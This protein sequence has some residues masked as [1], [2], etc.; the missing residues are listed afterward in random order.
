MSPPSQWYTVQK[1]TCASY[2]GYRQGHGKTAGV[3]AGSSVRATLLL[4]S[5]RNREAAVA[6][7]LL[8]P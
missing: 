8:Q 3:R 5:A 1:G 2:K 6:S 7:R 4:A